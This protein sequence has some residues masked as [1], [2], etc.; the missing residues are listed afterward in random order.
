MIRS[1]G[2]GLSNITRH[3]E[4]YHKSIDISVPF[5]EDSVARKGNGKQ[6]ADLRVLMKLKIR[7][8]FSKKSVEEREF[9]RD[10]AEWVS[11]NMIPLDTPE[12][13]GFRRILS[14]RDERCHP[15]RRQTITRE[16][17]K[18][19]TEAIESY[20][21]HMAKVDYVAGTTDLWTAE[22]GDSY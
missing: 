16:L 13:V 11:L 22:N 17:K 2:N 1:I 9:M 3:S 8:K 14:R 7:K 6:Q 21:G 15:L 10:C 5:G 20:K 19:H 12:Q 4:Q 18:I